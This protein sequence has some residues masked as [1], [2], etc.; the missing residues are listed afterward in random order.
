MNPGGADG[1]VDGAGAGA[2]SVALLKL[3]ARCRDAA[4]LLS[5][6]GASGDEGDGCSRAGLRLR[7][8]AV[9]V[10]AEDAV[11]VVTLVGRLARR[12]CWQSALWSFHGSRLGSIDSD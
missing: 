1:D 4:R 3:F 5:L 11:G 12:G 2:V 8:A 9:A 6:V 7:A 10:S